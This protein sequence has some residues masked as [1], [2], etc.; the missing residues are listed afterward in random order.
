MNSARSG[1]VGQGWGVRGATVHQ[2]HNHLEIS[3]TMFFCRMSETLPLFKGIIVVMVTGNPHSPLSCKRLTWA[4]QKYIFYTSFSR[5][6]V[7]RDLI[8]CCILRDSS[9]WSSNKFSFFC[10]KFAI[11]NSL[12]FIDFCNVFTVDDISL[13]SASTFA[14]RFLLCDNKSSFSDTSLSKAKH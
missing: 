14:A 11:L 6:F 2:V 4:K 1:R 13:C 9:S 7:C 5:F 3:T 12:S 8:C 10:S